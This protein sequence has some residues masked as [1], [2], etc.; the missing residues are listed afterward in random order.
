MSAARSLAILIALVA[1]IALGAQFVVASRLPE[2]AG[3]VAVLWRMAGYFTVLTNLAVFL[4]FTAVTF[5]GRMPPGRAGALVLCA[6][7]TGIVY[8]AVLSGLWAPQGLAWWADQGLHSATPLLT[9]LWWL[10]FAPPTRPD[11]TQVA[12]WLLWPLAYCGY[13]VARGAVT[14][15]WP[16]P[17][18]DPGLHG[19]LGV[20]ANIAGMMAAFA[21]VAMLIALID[22]RRFS[23]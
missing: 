23:R 17:F 22:R 6:G 5:G 7:M 4:Q 11:G 16:Y 15:F 8:H 10:A 13:V 14:G 2:L 19:P 20:A 21:A 9:V 3:T 18:L 12:G 1:G